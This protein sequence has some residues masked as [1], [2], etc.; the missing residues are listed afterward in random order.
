MKVAKAHRSARNN[1]TLPQVSKAVSSTTA[2]PVQSSGRRGVGFDDVASARQVEMLPLR[3]LKP[4]D[5]NARTHSKSQIQQLADAMKTFGFINPII[6]DGDRNIIAGHA[7]ALSAKLLGHKEV[8][9]I[10]VSHLSEAEVRAYM[11]ADNKL[12]EN[13]GWDRERLALELS[14]LQLVLPEIGLDIE[15]TGFAP[16]E[17]DSLMEDFTEAR[18]NPLDDIPEIEDA[19]VAKEG[20]IFVLG[21]HRIIVGDARVREVYA[22]LMRNDVAE[23]A[24]LDPPY[25]VKINGHVG[26]RGQTKHR[27]FAHASGEMNSRQFIQFLTTALGTTAQFI[28]DGGIVYVCMDWRHSSELL[29]AGASAFDELKNICVW[30]KSNA[31]QGSFYRSQHELVFVYKRGRA[32]HINTFELGQHGRSRSNV[33]NYAGVNSFRAGRMDE[34]KMHPTVKPVALIA[35]AMRDCS[36]RGSI[37]LGSFAGSGSSLPAAEQVGRRA[38]CIEIDPRYVDVTIRR[39]QG[40]TRKDAVLESSGRTFDEI[41]HTA[42]RAITGKS[43]A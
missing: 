20:D 35:D 10:S 5:R 18:A 29:E 12:A 23:M 41:H 28:K 26:G 1:A 4:A 2:G 17:I 37:I 24:F 8:P 6:V 43:N 21:H 30:A 40:A 15:I 27:E 11:L 7:R 19:V 33:W 25:N 32:P 9:T 34:L 22:R 38:H 13:S 3:T 31:G 16:G 36:R 42:K 14:E 39:W